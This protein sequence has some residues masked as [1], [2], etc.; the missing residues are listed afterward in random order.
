[1]EMSQ[2]SLVKNICIV[3]VGK[4]LG[5]WRIQPGVKRMRKLASVDWLT[6]RKQGLVLTDLLIFQQKPEDWFYIKISQT[7][8]VAQ[9][10]WTMWVKQNIPFPPPSFNQLMT[11][12]LHSLAVRKTSP[13][14]KEAHSVFQR[15]WSF[16]F[17]HIFG[18]GYLTQML[19][20]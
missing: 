12:S 14:L 4:T 3:W 11:L 19:E 15:L 13:Y 9:T 16:K 5:N 6:G 7:L 20:H 18:P 8:M 17:L 1:M 2:T 10:F